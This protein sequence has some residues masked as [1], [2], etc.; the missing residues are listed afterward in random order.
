[1][2]PEIVIGIIITWLVI[3]ALGTVNNWILEDRRY[4]Q[5]HA[6]EWG[7]PTTDALVVG[8][9][10]PSRSSNS[11]GMELDCRRL[12]RLVRQGDNSIPTNSFLWRSE[13]WRMW[14][15]K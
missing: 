14:F 11:E 7:L 8:M 10:D 5:A 12:A 4:W 3:K 1:L 15:G 9:T 2:I 6:Q 13:G